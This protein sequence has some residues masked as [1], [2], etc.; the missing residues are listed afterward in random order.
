MDQP[1]PLSL[2]WRG[3]QTTRFDP[4]VVDGPGNLAYYF[5]TGNFLTEGEVL[6]VYNRGVRLFGI[7]GEGDLFV[8]GDIAI[9]GAVL[10]APEEKKFQT[11]SSIWE[12]DHGRNYKPMVEVYD[13]SYR[14]MISAVVHASDNIIKVEHTY[15]ATGVLRI[16]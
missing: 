4:G 3:A 9:N 15:A 7:N 2:L 16:I 6:A 14:R 11:G 5:D 13:L 12:W 8:A 1:A 10:S